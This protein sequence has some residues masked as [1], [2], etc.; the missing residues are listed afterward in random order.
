MIVNS[1]VS[2]KLSPGQKTQRL[3]VGNKVPKDVLEFWKKNGSLESLKKSGVISD[4]NSSFQ[5]SEP[6]KNLKIED[7][8]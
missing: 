3:T 5:K 1:P 8:K 2:V 6:E 7:K 4:E